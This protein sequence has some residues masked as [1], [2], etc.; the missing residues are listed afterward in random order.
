[1]DENLRLLLFG[2]RTT[3]PEIII[4]AIIY[5]TV[6]TLNGTMKKFKGYNIQKR[7]IS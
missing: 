6:Y 7:M 4:S 1:M 5:L 3:C 2:L